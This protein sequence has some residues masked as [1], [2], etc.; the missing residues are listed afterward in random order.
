MKVRITKEELFKAAGMFG[1]VPI[2]DFIE[3]EGNPV[4]VEHCW[5]CRQFG[6]I[7]C[8]CTCHDQVEENALWKAGTPHTEDN[9]FKKY[10]L[11]VEEKCEH[12]RTFTMLGRVFCS[13]CDKELVKPTLIEELGYLKAS[14]NETADEYLSRALGIQKEKI[15]EVIRRLNSIH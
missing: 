14:R 11:S 2:P 3:L 15:N 13:E 10:P 9:V 7:N 12:E 5:R 1:K 8:P 4:E 6:A